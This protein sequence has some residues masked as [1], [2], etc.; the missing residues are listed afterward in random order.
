MF[1]GILLIHEEISNVLIIERFSEN[2]LK[3]FLS[4]ECRPVLVHS[5]EMET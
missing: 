5:R 4:V 3:K 1:V 2:L